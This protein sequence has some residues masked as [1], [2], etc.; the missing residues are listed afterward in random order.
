MRDTVEFSEQQLKRILR[1]LAPTQSRGPNPYL[2]VLVVPLAVALV[3]GLITWR[4][5]VQ[6][7][8]I[9][10]AQTM[11]KFVAY[12]GRQYSIEQQIAALTT[13]VELGYQDQAVDFLVLTF[14]TKPD[15]VRSQIQPFVVA[16]GLKLLPRLCELSVAGRNSS[17]SKIATDYVWDIVS[18]LVVPDSHGVAQSS[19]FDLIEKL[20]LEGDTEAQV[21]QGALYVL[22]MILSGAE[23][24]DAGF[25]AQQQDLVALFRGWPGLEQRL[26]S[27]VQ[28]A[29]PESDRATAMRCLYE[30]KTD[31][32]AFLRGV[33]ENREAGD[34]PRLNALILLSLSVHKSDQTAS[35]FKAIVSDRSQ[36]AKLRGSAA[37]VIADPTNEQMFKQ[38]LLGDGSA[39]DQLVAVEGL[40]KIRE[41]DSVP[42]LLEA[43]TKVADF[44]VKRRIL[45]DLA[46][47]PDSDQVF[48]R[49]QSVAKSDRD[50]A[51]RREA[52]AALIQM[53]RESGARDIGAIL[54][55]G[56]KDPDPN[57]LEVVLRFLALDGTPQQRRT[58]LGRIA[59]LEDPELK[60]QLQTMLRIFHKD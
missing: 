3:G 49:L 8:A 23:Q 12:F 29:A 5:N 33:L 20:A 28:S 51:L 44:E 38:W 37:T 45:A 34:L 50:P 55:A 1:S 15:L 14:G 46:L 39:D 17:V 2:Q 13:M 59:K 16:K 30:I 6:Q 58:A 27:F 32:D 54:L 24:S 19:A 47:F 57:V 43:Y 48:Q 31:A 26:K 42:V 11:E 60:A 25:P 53:G 40:R 41:K 56:L 4:Y 36:P 9:N 7:T 52:Y 18:R 21:R 22:E 10:R 35:L